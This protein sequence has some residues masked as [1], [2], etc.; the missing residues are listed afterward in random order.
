MRRFAGFKYAADPR[1]HISTYRWVRS[2]YIHLPLS[3]SAFAVVATQVLRRLSSPASA[4]SR[5][6]TMATTPEGRK[7]MVVIGG[8]YVGGKAVE[9]L[10][11]A[12][13]DKHNVVLVEKNSHFQVSS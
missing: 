6:R 10:I 3:H 8:S 7:N 11:T 1:I 9:E 4:F 5:I 12:F 2:L 13:G